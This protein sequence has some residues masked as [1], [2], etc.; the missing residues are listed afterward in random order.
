MLLVLKNGLLVMVLCKKST[1]RVLVHYSLA[2]CL[3]FDTEVT[4]QHTKL[5][6]KTKILFCSLVEKILSKLWCILHIKILQFV[7]IAVLERYVSRGYTKQV[8]R[9]HL[10]RAGISKTLLQA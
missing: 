8:D 3:H 5:S 9:F 4:L 1:V 2:F 7:T 10:D 6:C